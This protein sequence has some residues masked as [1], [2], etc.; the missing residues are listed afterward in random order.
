MWSQQRRMLLAS[1]FTVMLPYSLNTCIYNQNLIKF[2]EP[3]ISK[4]CT[5][6][7][8]LHSLKPGKF[9]CI[10]MQN[11][12]SKSAF[13]FQWWQILGFQLFQPFFQKDSFIWKKKAKT[14]TYSYC[15]YRDL[16]DKILKK[17]IFVSQ[18]WEWDSRS[19]QWQYGPKRNPDRC[20]DTS[21]SDIWLFLAHVAVSAP[22]LS[23]GTVRT[24]R[25]TAQRHWT[26]GSFDY[27]ASK[28]IK[29]PT[30]WNLTK[31]KY[32][33]KESVLHKAAKRRSSYASYFLFQL[34][35]FMLITVKTLIDVQNI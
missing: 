35:H 20:L 23:Y 34:L 11:S 13:S 30:Y 19:G 32:G 9:F 12:T 5:Q 33:V 1:G 27:R 31:R 26:L 8:I 2:A 21:K 18:N 16:T 15:D 14:R 22:L 29:V 17:P 10:L 7:W 25:C 3:L 24:E 4:I 6:H 28:N